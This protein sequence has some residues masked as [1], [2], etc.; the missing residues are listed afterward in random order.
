MIALWQ[1]SQENYSQPLV[2]NVLSDEELRE[3]LR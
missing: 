2:M 3:I 1:Q